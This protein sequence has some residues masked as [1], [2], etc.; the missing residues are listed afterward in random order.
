MTQWLK[1]VR[2]RARCCVVEV[3][4]SEKSKE[5]EEGIES[6]RKAVLK[7]ARSNVGIEFDSKSHP[8][9]TPAA[10]WARTGRTGVDQGQTIVILGWHA[11]TC[12]PH[13]SEILFAEATLKNM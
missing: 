3:H 10:R 8:T 1:S 9:G 4:Q 11:Q 5:R 2:A 7:K 13:W 12:I 6:Q